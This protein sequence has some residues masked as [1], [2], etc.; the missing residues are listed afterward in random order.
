M[1]DTNTNLTQLTVCSL[2][3]LTYLV[4]GGPLGQQLSVVDS[5]SSRQDLLTPHEHV[6]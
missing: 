1:S 4:M 5:L 3:T 6:V 2:Y